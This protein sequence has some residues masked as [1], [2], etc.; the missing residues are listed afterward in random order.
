MET[1]V[2]IEALFEAFNIDISYIYTRCMRPFY[3]S[4]SIVLIKFVYTISTNILYDG[5]C[6]MTSSFCAKRMHAYTNTNTHILHTSIHTNIHSWI[7]FVITIFCT[8]QI[9]RL[10]CRLSNCVFFFTSFNQCVFNI[11]ICQMKAPIFL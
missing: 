4:I 8:L 9:L 11:A 2:Q 7:W 1:I 3:S 6:Y 5:F 10:A